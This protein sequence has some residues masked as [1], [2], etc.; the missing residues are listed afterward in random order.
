MNDFEATASYLLPYDPVSKKHTTGAKRGLAS[1]S[2]V[3]EINTAE[4]SSVTHGGKSKASIGK[5]GVEF[6]YYK[7]PEY[8]LLRAEQKAELKEHRDGKKSSPGQGKAKKT[9]FAN[10]WD[11]SKQKQWIASAVEKQLAQRGQ[12]VQDADTTEEEFK[13]YIMSLISSA[14]PA[15]PAAATAQTKPLVTLN[16]ILS[17]DEVPRPVLL[18]TT[19]HFK[20]EEPR[21]M[22]INAGIL[23]E[24]RMSTPPT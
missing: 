17:L 9:R 13:S 6:R 23:A 15:T 2:D 7:P 18:T 21:Q 16:S 20:G 3:S 19:R 12:D 5:T 24:T 22:K 10:T 11:D 1:I 8:N 14:K 4:I